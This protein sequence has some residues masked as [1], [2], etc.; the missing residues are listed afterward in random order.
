MPGS[1]LGKM[2]KVLPGGI[3][4][5]KAAADYGDS[6][7]AGICHHVKSRGK[8]AAKGR[9]AVFQAVIMYACFLLHAFHQDG[10]RQLAANVG[11]LGEQACDGAAGITVLA[12]GMHF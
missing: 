6:V 5:R 1:P 12:D 8:E 2:A 11:G 10:A 3:R 4:V 7:H 9:Q